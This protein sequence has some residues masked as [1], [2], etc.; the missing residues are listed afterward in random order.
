MSRFRRLGLLR[1]F[2]SLSPDAAHRFLSL[3]ANGAN[4]QT[5]NF[6]YGLLTL[7]VDFVDESVP[8]WTTPTVPSDGEATAETADNSAG[9]A[10]SEVVNFS[11]ATSS[12]AETT[13]AEPDTDSPPSEPAA[14]SSSSRSSD[15]VEKDGDARADARKDS[16]DGI[17]ST[18]KAAEESGAEERSSERSKTSASSEPSDS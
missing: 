15:E 9:D 17:A 6:N 13:P 8:R 18:R 5:G 1:G 2:G 16:A 7:L 11:S 14:E 10:A 3:L 4:P 12:L